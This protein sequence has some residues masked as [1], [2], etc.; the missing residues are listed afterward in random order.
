M[1]LPNRASHLIISYKCKCN[2]V[3][4]LLTSSLL[5]LSSSSSKHNEIVKPNA[6]KTLLKSSSVRL[7]LDNLPTVAQ[8]FLNVN[9]DKSTEFV[10]VLSSDVQRLIKRTGCSVS[11]IDE[12]SQPPIIQ[13]TLKNDTFHSNKNLRKFGINLSETTRAKI[14]EFHSNI[15]D[16]MLNVRLKQ[17]ENLLRTNHFV[18]LIIYLINVKKTF[19]KNIHS[20]IMKVDGYETK[21]ESKQQQLENLRKIEYENTVQKF[22]KLLESIPSCKVRTVDRPDLSNVVITLEPIQMN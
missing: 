8:Q 3:Y 1:N 14:I 6:Y 13:L 15:D 18:V 5:A 21:Q 4:R 19:E 12:N 20:M 7:R 22:T 16:R 9:P 17:A 11:F 2:T 10:V